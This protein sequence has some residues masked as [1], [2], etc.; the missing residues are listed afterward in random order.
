[1][2]ASVIPLL[3]DRDDLDPVVWLLRLSH[4]ADEIVR[5]KAVEAMTGKDSAEV[6]T[7]LR[8][9]AA[10]DASAA[11]RAA[12]G[13]LVAASAASETTAALPP[14]PGSPSL[15]PEGELTDR[16]PSGSIATGLASTAAQSSV[17]PTGPSPPSRAGARSWSSGQVSATRAGRRGSRG[18]ASGPPRASRPSGSS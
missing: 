15:T 3:K 12:A 11:V 2:R 7:R 9:M 6:R 4:D 8:E 1:M 10:K 13:K 17:R 5:T 16:G 18:P 14:L